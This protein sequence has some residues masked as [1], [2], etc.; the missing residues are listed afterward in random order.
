MR[1]TAETLLGAQW[2][3]FEPDAALLARAP[4]LADRKY[5]QPGYNRRR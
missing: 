1:A 4:E 2:E 3:L 5:S